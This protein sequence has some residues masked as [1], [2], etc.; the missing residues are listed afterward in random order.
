MLRLERTGTPKDLGNK[1]GIS[2]RTLYEYIAFMK[3]EL[4]APIVYERQ[5]QSYKY[6]SECK[7][8]FNGD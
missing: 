5:K 2:T 7:L 8:C 4:N 6:I 3:Q 1:L